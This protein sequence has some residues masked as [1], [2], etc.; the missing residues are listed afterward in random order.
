MPSIK[1]CLKA[2]VSLG[3]WIWLVQRVNWG[4]VWH[5]V[6]GLPW[7]TLPLSVGIYLLAQWY[8]TWRW[9]WFA[10]Q[11]G[12]AVPFKQMWRWYLAGMV[13]NQLLPGTIGGD[14]FKVWQ[15]AQATQKP[16]SLALVTVLAERGVGLLAM[17]GLGLLAGQQLPFLPATLKPCLLVFQGL[18][19]MAVLGV[20]LLLAVPWHR[21]AWLNW[22]TPAQQLIK[23]P[24]QCL[25]TN[26]V[27]SVGSALFKSLLVS[28][29]IQCLMVTLHAL[30]IPNTVQMAYGLTWSTLAWA[31]ASV[32][33]LTLLPVSLNGMGLRE[34]G[35]I[36]LLAPYCPVEV[37]TSLSLL[38]FA[39][40]LVTSCW[41][42]P[43]VFGKGLGRTG[44]ARGLGAG[45]DT[46]HGSENGNE[47]TFK[48]A[49]A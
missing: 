3:I 1:S 46:G 13:Y 31:Y 32:S 41:G 30:L 38:W 11:L 6:S 27:K 28:V 16:K 24:L 23:A 22:L 10:H 33:I 48:H 29:I 39:L 49:S 45:L 44:H 5:H 2:L 42:I 4:Q 37:S 26:P 12:M 43:F 17:L 25:F 36:T 8:S 20:V 40:G 19:C 47:K 21:W 14:G 9:Y 18:G 35:Y 7:W 15:L 34:L